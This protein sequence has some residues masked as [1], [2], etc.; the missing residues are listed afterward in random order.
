M[1]LLQG[2][3]V[4]LTFKVATKKLHATCHPN[5]VIISVK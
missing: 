1:I 2:N 5:M 4:T 3:A